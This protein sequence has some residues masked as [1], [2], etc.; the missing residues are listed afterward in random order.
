MRKWKKEPPD[1][2]SLLLSRL[3]VKSTLQSRPISRSFHRLHTLE[4]LR[5][6]SS[7][8]LVWIRLFIRVCCF[9]R[10]S[11]SPRTS[12]ICIDSIRWAQQ[13]HGNMFETWWNYK[14]E[15][16]SVFYRSYHRFE[17]PFESTS[18]LQVSPSCL[19]SRQIR[20]SDIWISEVYRHWG[21]FWQNCGYELH[22]CFA[23]LP[24]KMV[25][26]HDVLRAQAKT[27][28]VIIGWCGFSWTV[29]PLYFLTCTR[30]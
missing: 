20:L 11:G 5:S 2:L 4:T 26:K 17:H 10:L 27:Q 6:E 8:G 14:I 13:V 25:V 9:Q 28:P 24:L 12:N 1:P 19:W 15:A 3:L 21:C 16:F 22:K 18:A 29:Q 23:I 30:C 7:M